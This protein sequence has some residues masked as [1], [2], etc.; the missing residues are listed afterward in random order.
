MYTMRW[1]TAEP[2]MQNETVE[3]WSPV[4]AYFDIQALG[5]SMVLE[6]SVRTDVDALR[7]C[8]STVANL[9]MLAS[10]SST[11]ITAYPNPAL[12]KPDITTSTNSLSTSVLC[13]LMRTMLQERPHDVTRLTHADKFAASSSTSIRHST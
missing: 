3:E 6:L 10:P 7:L 13:G 11:S 8:A 12:N 5:V 9:Q 2:L 4:E 1:Q